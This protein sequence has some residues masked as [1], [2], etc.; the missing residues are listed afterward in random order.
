MTLGDRGGVNIGRYS[1]AVTFVVV[2]ADRIDSPI[3]RRPRF[4]RGD[5]SVIIVDSVSNLLPNS[6]Y[7]PPYVQ[8]PTEDNR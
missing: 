4:C 2:L 3:E 8:E 7:Y 1:Y 6:S 5:S